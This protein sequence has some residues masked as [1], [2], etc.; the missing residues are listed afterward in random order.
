MSIADDFGAINRAAADLRKVPVDPSLPPP[1][2]REAWVNGEFYALLALDQQLDPSCFTNHPFASFEV[3]EIQNDWHPV[4]EIAQAGDGV[5][6]GFAPPE[7]PLAAAEAF[8]GKDGT[9][10]FMGR[11]ATHFYELTDYAILSKP[12]AVTGWVENTLTVACDVRVENGVIV[13]LRPNAA[14]AKRRVGAVIYVDGKVDYEA[15][16]ET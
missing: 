12:P 1:T 14:T 8:C 2:R 11:R 3:R 9:M 15:W 16:S 10:L 6:V 4:A 7:G 5:L 13:E